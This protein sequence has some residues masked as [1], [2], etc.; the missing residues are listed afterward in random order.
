[1]VFGWRDAVIPVQ[2]G[3]QFAQEHH[4]SLHVLDSG[5]RLNDVLSDVGAIFDN[6]LASISFNK[7]T[8]D[9]KS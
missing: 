3:I 8:G 6:Y 4:A 9:L 1:M 5:H 2:N 7:K